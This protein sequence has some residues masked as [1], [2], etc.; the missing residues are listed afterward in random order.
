MLKKM[1]TL[2]LALLFAGSLFAQN[3]H[4]KKAPVLVH[5]PT[6]VSTV[7]T[8]SNNATAEV[9]KTNAANWVLVD[10]MANCYG[11]AIYAINPMA[12]D[13][14]TGTVAFINR[15]VASLGGSG[16]L[17]YSFSTDK[18]ATWARAAGPLNTGTQSPLRGRY[19]SMAISN[20]TKSANRSDALGVFAWPALDNA[21]A[22][23][24]LTGY[25]ADQP[26]G[27]GASF[28]AILDM[29]GKFS[30]QTPIWTGDGNSRVFWT[31]DYSDTPSGKPFLQSVLSYTDDFGTVDSVF[32][33]AFNDPNNG[34]LVNFGGVAFGNT[35]YMGFISRFDDTL[36]TYQ[37]WWPC[38]MKST[39]NGVTWSDRMVVDF[40]SIPALAKYNQLWD[41][42]YG[43]TFVS[44]CGDVNVD[45]DGYL[46][47][48][49]P[50][51]E[52]DTNTA[53]FVS[54][55]IVE[56][57]ET[58][59]GWSGKVVAE[60]FADSL[61]FSRW[62]VDNEPGIGQMGP[63]PYLAVNKTRDRFVCQWVAP[64]SLTD[65]LCDVFV[66]G[67]SSGAW[68]RATNITSTPL[69]NESGSHLAPFIDG[70][71]SGEAFTAF[72]AYWYQK[73]VTTH[74]IVPTAVANIYAAAVPVTISG[75]EG[76]V[77]KANAFELSQNYP[78]PFNPATSIRFN[79][80]EAGNVSLKVYDVLGREVAT[81]VNGAMS[82][83]AHSVSFNGSD[84]ASGLYIYKLEAG[85]TTA[86][87]K[88]MLLK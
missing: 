36:G 45:K 68:G 83:G 59:N 49:T 88:M 44:Y 20:P 1:S 6:N 48:V 57:F 87:K 39:D 4:M 43:D 61:A 22:G 40:T 30:S 15:S 73:G 65:S 2:F 77:A 8:S 29:D 7:V 62:T 33:A 58:A 27:Q 81:L 16:A 75:V 86:V 47:M 52:R 13:P 66:A 24:D 23:F 82:Q 5:E 28:A 70:A 64:P 21:G 10:S 67:R 12:Y 41:Y 50:L 46:H 71:S 79:L 54:A 14:Y 18:G 76:K 74:P 85:N 78:N 25:G 51:V 69:M 37:G 56:L 80:S 34:G 11:P 63:A 55:A 53:K 35:V 26:I 19:P 72:S 84:L 38:Y 60:N 3:Q 17:Y 32:P 42:K 31:S 9:A